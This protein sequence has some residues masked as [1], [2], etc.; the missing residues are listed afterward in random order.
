MKFSDVGSIVCY[1]VQYNL[2]VREKALKDPQHSIYSY[3]GA[4]RV[5]LN[6]NISANSSTSKKNIQKPHFAVNNTACLLYIITLTLIYYTYM[7][8]TSDWSQF[9]VFYGLAEYC[10]NRK[11]MKIS[12]HSIVFEVLSQ[13]FQFLVYPYLY[14]TLY[15]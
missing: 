10:W 7:K 9:C 14:F 4:S 3:R 8:I 2:K 13:S 11:R 6:C 1:R 15:T 5:K 12:Y